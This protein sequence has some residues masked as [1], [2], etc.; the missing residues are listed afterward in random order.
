[1]PC[2]PA[3]TPSRSNTVG[4]G[5]RMP[6]NGSNRDKS[7]TCPVPPRVTGIQRGHHGECAGDPRHAIGQAK[8]RQRGRPVFLPSLMANPLMARRACRR[9]AAL[10]GAVLPKTRHPQH[11]QARVDFLELCRTE[12]HFHHARTEVLDQYVGIR[13]QSAQNVLA[14]RFAEVEGHRA[15]VAGDDLVPQAMS[16]VVPTMGPRRISLRMLNLDHI[17]TEVA[18]QHPGDRSGIHRADI[19]Y[20]GPRQRFVGPAALPLPKVAGSATSSLSAPSA[21]DVIS[22]S[23]SRNCTAGRS[24]DSVCCHRVI[25]ARQTKK[26]VSPRTM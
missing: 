17:G 19:Q 21:S 24:T 1:M 26:K 18:Q 4:P 2:R 12:P 16:L 20:A 11:D 7:M 3:I 8:W 6:N 23:V 14:G 22:P 10:V 13:N 9:R 5:P 15:L 25:H